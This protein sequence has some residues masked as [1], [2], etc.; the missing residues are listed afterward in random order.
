[1]L[2]KP[3]IISNKSATIRQHFKIS[4]CNKLCTLL[5]YQRVQPYGEFQN[6]FIYFIHFCNFLLLKHCIDVPM[7]VINYRNKKLFLNK[8]S[9]V[10]ADSKQYVFKHCTNTTG[11]TPF[12]FSLCIQCVEYIDRNRIYKGMMTTH[13]KNHLHI[14]E[15]SSAITHTA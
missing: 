15:T 4:L 14:L 12:N 6:I 10:Q 3:K 13:H 8:G 7:V 1:M 5:G 11:S 9:C 2:T